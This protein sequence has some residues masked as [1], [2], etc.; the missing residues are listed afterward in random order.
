MLLVKHSTF[1]EK[2]VSENTHDKI[3][4]DAVVRSNF[5]FQRKT[6]GGKLRGGEN[7]P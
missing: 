5:E 1:G 6:Q 3:L 2:E 4:P 7:I